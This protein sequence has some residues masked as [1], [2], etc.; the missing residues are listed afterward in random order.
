VQ[1]F[2][3]EYKD[4]YTAI[5]ALLDAGRID[6]MT[7]TNATVQALLASRNAERGNESL[8][9]VINIITRAAHEGKFGIDKQ[10]KIERAAGE[11]VPVLVKAAH[12]AMD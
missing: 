7:A 10:E 8:A 1:I 3:E 5:N 2:G 11:L 12:R 4:V 9:D 6:G